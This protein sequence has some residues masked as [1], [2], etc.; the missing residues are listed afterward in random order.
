MYQPNLS[1]SLIHIVTDQPFRM[2]GKPRQSQ[3]L[4]L[5]NMV[6]EQGID[7]AIDWF[8][9]NGK[10]APWGGTTMLLAQKLMDDGYVEEGLRFMEFEVESQPEKVWLLRKTAEAYLSHG[11]PDKALALAKRGLEIKPQDEKLILL[12]KE[13][14][15]DLKAEDQ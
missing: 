14:E 13:A 10:K 9:E 11:S 8:R 2:P 12:S 4:R 5:Y 6:V 3:D 1:V 7:T 15:G